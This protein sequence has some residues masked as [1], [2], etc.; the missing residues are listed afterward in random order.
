MRANLIGF[1]MTLVFLIWVCSMGLDALA[2]APAADCTNNPVTITQ[3]GQVKSVTYTYNNGK[4]KTILVIRKEQALFP[5]VMEGH[6]SVP[7]E[8]SR[9]RVSDKLGRICSGQ[10]PNWKIEL[11]GW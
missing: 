3:V 5:L 2:A 6:F 4:P 7:T 1:V 9:V 10:E 8:G 11:A